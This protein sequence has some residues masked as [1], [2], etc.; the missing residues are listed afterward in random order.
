MS[1][2]QSLGGQLKPSLQRIVHPITT[3]VIVDEVRDPLRPVLEMAVQA[4]VTGQ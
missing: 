4:P 2:Q 3:N 1:G